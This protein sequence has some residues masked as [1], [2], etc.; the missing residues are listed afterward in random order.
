MG[1]RALG[2]SFQRG[3]LINQMECFQFGI[4]NAQLGS[5]KFQPVTCNLNFQLA[6]LKFPGSSGSFGSNFLFLAHSLN[7]SETPKESGKDP[8]TVCTAF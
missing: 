3:D 2:S 8:H 1:F 7:S 4:L 6:S 5:L